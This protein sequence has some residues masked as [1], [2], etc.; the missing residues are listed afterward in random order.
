MSCAEEIKAPERHAGHEGVRAM[1]GE[2]TSHKNRENE[3]GQKLIEG[4][5]VTVVMVEEI[6]AFGCTGRLKGTDAEFW[7]RGNS[8]RDREGGRQSLLCLKRLCL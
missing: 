1:L 8:Q 7:R 4:V 3:G 5:V 2:G 6:L